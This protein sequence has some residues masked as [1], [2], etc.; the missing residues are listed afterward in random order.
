M[1]RA[2]AGED[3]EAVVT[4]LEHAIQRE[5]QRG[6]DMVHVQRLAAAQTWFVPRWRRVI[7]GWMEKVVEA[8]SLDEVTLEN[9]IHYLDTFVVAIMR[10]GRSLESQQY[11]ATAMVSLLLSSKMYGVTGHQIT[12]SELIALAPQ[13]RLTREFLVNWELQFVATLHFNLFVTTTFEFMDSLLKVYAA[14]A[15][16]SFDLDAVTERAHYIARCI[17]GNLDSAEFSQSQRALTAVRGALAWGHARSEGLLDSSNPDALRRWLHQCL[18]VDAGSLPD[19]G[20]E[21]LDMVAH[22]AWMTE[23]ANSCG[24]EPAPECESYLFNLMLSETGAVVAQDNTTEAASPSSVNE[25]SG[26]HAV[27][28]ETADQLRPRD[29][30]F[31]RIPLQEQ[32]PSPVGVSNPPTVDSP[33]ASH[34]TPGRSRKRLLPASASQVDAPATTKR[35]KE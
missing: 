19:T 31:K 29:T 15:P 35:P 12:M 22:R 18:P 27:S 25:P 3:K 8:Y 4:W 5:Q 7:V 20:V 10:K 11:Q 23:L 6:D 2:R 17:R 34:S 14:H 26:S 1:A 13:L 9:A 32:S 21:S 16:E 28:P 30:K 33:T 24:L